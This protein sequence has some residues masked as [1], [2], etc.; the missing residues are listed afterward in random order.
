[1]EQRNRRKKSKLSKD[2]ALFRF[3]KRASL[4]GHVPERKKV[5]LYM[6]VRFHLIVRQCFYPTYIHGTLSHFTSVFTKNM[7]KP[8]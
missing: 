4:A 6:I 5:A 3:Q 8:M 2:V 7:M 1:M